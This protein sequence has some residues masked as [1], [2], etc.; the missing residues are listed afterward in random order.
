MS[1]CAH[2]TPSP[3]GEGAGG[4]AKPNISKL[5]H[6]RAE[7]IVAQRCDSPHPSIPAPRGEA[8]K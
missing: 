3:R 1:A 5:A 8:F 7:N 6:R 4:G 2:I